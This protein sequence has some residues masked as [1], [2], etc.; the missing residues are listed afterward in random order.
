MTMS[1]YPLRRSVLLFTFAVPIFLR[2]ALTIAKTASFS[3]RP[4]AALLLPLTLLA[5]PAFAQTEVKEDSVILQPD[6]V[7]DD[8]PVVAVRIEM[9]SWTEDNAT[10]LLSFIEKVGDEGLFA[11]DYNPDGLAAAI[12]GGDQ[13]ALDKAAPASCLLLPTP[14]PDRR[15]PER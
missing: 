12:L 15:P 7:K 9:P 14:L 10:A 8:A 13:A 2:W 6:K 4:A 5:A 3:A 11:R 1:F